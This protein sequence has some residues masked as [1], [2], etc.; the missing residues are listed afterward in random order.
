MEKFCPKHIKQ[1][2][3]IN[4]GANQFYEIGLNPFIFTLITV[5]KQLISL[6]V[7][8]LHPYPRGYWFVRVTLQWWYTIL[9]L[10]LTW[11]LLLQLFVVLPLSLPFL[12]FLVIIVFVILISII[13][14]IFVVVFLSHQYLGRTVVLVDISPRI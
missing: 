7:G 10:L 9:L 6:L 4:S 3:K 11:L 1:C 14:I 12:L 2:N 5:R 8:H 13:V